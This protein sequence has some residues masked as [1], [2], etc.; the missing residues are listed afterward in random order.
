MER[1]CPSRTNSSHCQS[2]PTEPVE[3]SSLY[4]KNLQCTY[5]VRHQP[6]SHPPQGLVTDD[7]N[8]MV[9]IIEYVK[10]LVQKAQDI[11]NWL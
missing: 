6:H 7:D 11:G 3:T 1:C 9:V 4:T 10:H 2:S 5:L 8:R